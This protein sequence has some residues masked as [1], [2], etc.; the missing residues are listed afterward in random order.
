[1][2]WTVKMMIGGRSAVYVWALLDSQDATSVYGHETNMK[3]IRTQRAANLKALE[4]R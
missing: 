1:L 2:Q 4:A 3:N